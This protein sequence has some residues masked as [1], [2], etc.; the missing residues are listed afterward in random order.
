[1]DRLPIHWHLERIV[2]LLSFM[3]EVKR[4]EN[5]DVAC[6]L[7]LRIKGYN[8]YRFSFNLRLQ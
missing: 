5:Q 3:I 2:K 7:H 4:K 8:N 1:M 6:G